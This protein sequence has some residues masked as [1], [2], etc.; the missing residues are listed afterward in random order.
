MYVAM[1]S[2]VVVYVCMHACIYIFYICTYSCMW[3]QTLVT[4]VSD[5]LKSYLHT[6][7]LELHQVF[8]IFWPLNMHWLL[9]ELLQLLVIFALGDVMKESAQIALNWI[10]SN[11]QWVS[12]CHC[13]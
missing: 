12:Q 9:N 5:Q 10:R 4:Y 11:D 7:V 3:L 8:V 2:Y 13:V 6:C 1:Y